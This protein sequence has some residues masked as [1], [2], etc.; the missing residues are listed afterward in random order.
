MQFPLPIPNLSQ[1]LISARPDSKKTSRK[2]AP[3]PRPQTIARV[4]SPSFST[5]SS[6]SLLDLF[7]GEPTSS[8]P[9]LSRKLEGPAE[10]VSSSS[11]GSESMMRRRLDLDRVGRD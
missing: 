2:D 7:L 6:F 5:S 11:V 4:F 9:F 10:G 8:S 3:T 1:V